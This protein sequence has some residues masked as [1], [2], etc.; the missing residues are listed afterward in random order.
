MVSYKV[1]PL[2]T[3]AEN[4]KRVTQNED[5]LSQFEVVPLDNNVLDLN[6]PTLFVTSSFIVHSYDE[7][8]EVYNLQELD[9][10]Y[11]GDPPRFTIVQQI[12]EGRNYYMAERIENLQ[13][14]RAN[15]HLPRMAITEPNQVPRDYTLRKSFEVQKPYQVWAMVRIIK[16][17]QRHHQS[18]SMLQEMVDGNFSR[19]NQKTIMA[20]I[21]VFIGYLF[22]KLFLF[23]F[24]PDIIDRVLNFLF[25]AVVLALGVWLWLT[26]TKNLEKFKAVYKG[27]EGWGTVSDTDPK[28]RGNQGQSPV[29]PPADTPSL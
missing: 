3:K 26:V 20:F 1:D 9:I 19:F 8:L 25:G 10:E 21:A 28:Y 5:V 16:N 18:E 14:M 22:L 29:Q 24:T 7:V 27:Y 6:S 23:S 12:M 11:L 13:K 2:E 17:H 15:E 4:I